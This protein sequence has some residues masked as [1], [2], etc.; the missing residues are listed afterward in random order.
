MEYFTHTLF[1]IASFIS[2]YVQVF[3]LVTFFTEQKKEKAL[4]SA[5]I[6]DQEHPP[7]TVIVPCYN[8]QNTLRGTMDSLLE[9]KYPV[10]KLFIIIVDDGSI[11]G[12]KE[13]MQEY[14]H[15]QN[16]SLIFQHNQGKHVA[17][18]TALAQTRTP[19]VGCLDADSRVDALALLHIMS[20]FAADQQ[21]MAVTPTMRVRNPDSLLQKA[22]RAEYDIG[23]FQKL[24]LGW[25]NG[26]HVTPGPFS[27]FRKKVFDE[28][29][30]Y[31]KAHNTEDQEIALRM[32]ANGYRIAH[33]KDAV[34]Y[35]NV[36]KTP[37]RLYLQRKRWTYGFLKNTLD[38]RYMIFNGKYGNVGLFTMPSAV[39]ALP[40]VLVLF[41][42]SVIQMG[43]G[44]YHLF[45]KLATL[46]FGI[47]MTTPTLDP[48]FI[49]TQ[50]LLFIQIILYVS[51]IIV[52]LLG[53]FLT[54]KRMPHVF[55]VFLLMILYAVIAPF[56]V[57]ASVW[58]VLRSK[59]TSWTKERNNA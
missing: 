52:F 25:L 47:T 4:A 8:E 15:L 10:D 46:H 9:L 21:I 59:E 32:Q 23:T 1:Y 43:K 55:D 38:Y 22:Q 16:V 2:L 28:L 35:T 40:F 14:A 58:N 11:D 19:F 26:I 57:I 53:R 48:F 33:A 7:V 31:R 49:N 50:P 12:T 27:I 3:F 34:V 29:G 6:F 54:T 18:N 51:V 13:V 41:F 36:P 42:L 37:R 20:A 44:I 17:L 39:V 24:L 56:W 5:T 45:D 30:N